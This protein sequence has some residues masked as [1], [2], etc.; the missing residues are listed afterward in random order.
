MK[1]FPGRTYTVFLIRSFLKTFIICI[2]FI[3]GLS[4]IVR[5]LQRMD[6]AREYT[7]VQ[8]VIIRVLEAP[9]I[10]SR[11]ALLASCMFASVYTMS[12]ITKNREILALRSC[13]VSIYRI[14]SPLIMVG[15]LIS[16]C[17]LLFEDYV[18]VKSFPLKKRYTAAISGEGIL[19]DLSDRANFVVF[20][21][22]NT[23]FNIKLF[24]IGTGEMKQVMVLKKNEEGSIRQRIDAE[25]ARW[26]GEE[27]I[28]YN[29]ASQVF[30]ERGEVL[31]QEVFTEYR[32]NIRDKPRYF[33]RNKRKI[34]DMTLR[35]GYEYLQVR[36]RMGL[37]AKGDLT[38]Y[39]RKIANAFT[40]FIIIVIGL[41]LGSIAFKNALVISFS[42]TLGIVLVFFFLIEIGYT[43]G[44]TGKL[45][46]VIGGWLGNIVFST[47]AII[48]LK[49]IR[50]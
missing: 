37:N 48:V 22:N 15:F 18:V 31:Q 6:S 45:S 44:S 36:K 4:F 46:P 24:T 13:G 50:K 42:L 40:L 28:F 38:R 10:I 29:G 14:L 34:E 30:G 19:S 23:I 17:S 12:I 35:E 47:G 21:E 27:W 9:E 32:D 7:F 26:N 43:F 8:T 3:M 5:T 11:E 25:S 39:N 49:K 20:G 16:I 41:S 33:A 2:I 1:C